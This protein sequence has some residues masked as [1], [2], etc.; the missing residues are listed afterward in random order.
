MVAFEGSQRNRL[1]VH[2][3]G[4]EFWVVLL[5]AILDTGVD[6]VVEHLVVEFL[7]VGPSL[8]ARSPL[9]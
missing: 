6:L 2:V 7:V 1:Q 4:R 8:L 9:H 5:V 3:E